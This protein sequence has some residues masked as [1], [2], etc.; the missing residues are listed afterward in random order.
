MLEGV[1]VG[2]RV[3]RVGVSSEQWALGVVAMYLRPAAL[4]PC[5]PREGGVAP[6]GGPKSRNVCLRGEG[7]GGVNS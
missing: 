3:D 1:S 7:R 4:Q 5:P 6:C 2:G